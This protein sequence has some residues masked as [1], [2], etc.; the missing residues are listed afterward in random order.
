M[1]VKCFI[2]GSRGTNSSCPETF[3]NTNYFNFKK[4]SEIAKAIPLVMGFIFRFQLVF[5]LFYDFETQLDAFKSFAEDISSDSTRFRWE[6]VRWGWTNLRAIK[7]WSR[8]HLFIFERQTIWDWFCFSHQFISD[9]NENFEFAHCFF[10]TH[11]C[12]LWQ[13]SFTAFTCNRH[14]TSVQVAKNGKASHMK[15]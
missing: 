3:V 5:C 6:K 9:V 10:I 14:C 12:Y 13:W 7:S 8:F 1:Q 11:G 15:C 4:E 2:S